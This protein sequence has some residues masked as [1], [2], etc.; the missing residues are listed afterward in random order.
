MSIQ[1]PRNIQDTKREWV[2]LVKNVLE[3]SQNCPLHIKIQC[4]EH[5]EYLEAS[6]AVLSLLADQSHR[7]R[8]LEISCSPIHLAFLSIVRNRLS[9][10]ASLEIEL[11]DTTEN[12]QIDTFEIAPQLKKVHFAGFYTTKLS[13]SYNQLTEFVDNRLHADLAVYRQ[14]LE[15]LRQGNNVQKFVARYTLQNHLDTLPTT[16]PIVCPSIQAFHACQGPLFRSVILPNL[17]QVS[18]DPGEVPYHHEGPLV[19]DL[20]ALG[21]LLTMIRQSYCQNT[22]TVISMDDVWVTDDI[23][24]IAKL[25]PILDEW[26]FSW[27]GWRHE[28]N[29]PLNKLVQGLSQKAARNGGET[30]TFSLLPTLSHLKF[31]IY[32][33]QDY[34]VMSLDFHGNGNTQ[35]SDRA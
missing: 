21:G 35:N 6:L 9:V 10:L 27:T 30:V 23:I 31:T 25:A 1:L 7:W 17:K 33:M 34:A 15:I 22:L 19:A 24:A 26:S 3:C 18:L 5:G 20:D 14:Y 4:G 12:R 16:P 32:D 28:N 13:V 11:L 8:H 2:C 29:R